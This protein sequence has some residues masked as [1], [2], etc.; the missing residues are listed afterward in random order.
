MS[1]GFFLFGF[2]WGGVGVWEGHNDFFLPIIMNSFEN[3]FFHAIILSA[4]PSFFLVL[5]SSSD[6]QLKRFWWKNREQTILHVICFHSSSRNLIVY[7]IHAA[8]C[9]LWLLCVFNFTSVK[10]ISGEMCHQFI[11]LF[12]MGRIHTC[13]WAQRI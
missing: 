4:S 2:F 7:A 13:L 11:R 9:I 5:K 10:M 3:Y 12:P 8:V 1:L 6:V